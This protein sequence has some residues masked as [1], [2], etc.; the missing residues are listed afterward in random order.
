M[1][2]ASV[3]LAPT[4]LAGMA[5]HLL[6][7]AVSVAIWAQ[8]G[9]CS[10][11]I[12]LARGLAILEIFLLFDAA[13]NWRWTLHGILMN[14]AIAANLYGRRELPQL[15]AL[16]LLSTLLLLAL[17][18]AIRHFCG[19]PGAVVASCAGLI[20]AGIWWVEVISFHATDAF[21]QH[22]LGPVMLIAALWI[23]PSL[24]AAAGIVWDARRST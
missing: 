9:S 2:S 23:V 14:F 17:I 24:M 16:A 20:S 22:F 15:A 19:R 11:S 12:R 18:L 3:W 13:F 5:S 21:L 4:R 1:I 6:A 8:P 7:A 10:R